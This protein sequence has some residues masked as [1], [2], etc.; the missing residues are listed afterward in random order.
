MKEY[1]ESIDKHLASIDF[2]E[3]VRETNT[4]PVVASY[5]S[6]GPFCE[7]GLFVKPDIMASETRVLGAW[8]PTR[9]TAQIGTNLGL[10]ML[11]LMLLV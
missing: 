4:P 9:P 11:P 5:T 7:F 10:N 1:I 8:I 3:A 6:K 2:Q